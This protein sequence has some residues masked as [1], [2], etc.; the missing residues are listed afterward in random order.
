VSKPAASAFGYRRTYT[1]FLARV[2]L[3]QGKR[4]A[5]PSCEVALN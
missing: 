2:L 4:C 1:A 5:D 3:S